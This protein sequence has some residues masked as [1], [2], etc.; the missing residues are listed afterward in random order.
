VSKPRNGAA[1]STRDQLPARKLSSLRYS[2]RES[3]CHGIS[4]CCFECLLPLCCWCWCDC[5]AVVAVMLFVCCCWSCVEL[6]VYCVLLRSGVVLLVLVLPQV[7]HLRASSKVASGIRLWTTCCR[8]T[9]F[10]PLF[11]YRSPREW[12]RVLPASATCELG[13]CLFASNPMALLQ[14]AL[15]VTGVGKSIVMTGSDIARSGVLFSKRI[16]CHCCFIARCYWSRQVDCYSFQPSLEV[17]I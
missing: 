15:A 12:Q 5:C 4:S 9:D 1:C 13:H 16:P 11:R 6:A 2:H 14:I 10:T 8:E 3:K 7:D 17:W